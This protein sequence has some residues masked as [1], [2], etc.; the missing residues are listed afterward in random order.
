MTFIC[1]GVSKLCCWN[2]VARGEDERP[3][4]DSSIRASPVLWTHCPGAAPPLPGAPSPGLR[5]S[6]QAPGPLKELSP[7]KA[8]GCI[9]LPGVLGPVEGVLPFP[10][11]FSLSLPLLLTALQSSDESPG[12]LT[13]HCLVSLL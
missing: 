7:R 5:A 1:S 8:N 9:A 11:A 3:V 4:V 6:F 2:V 10:V 13:G 12:W